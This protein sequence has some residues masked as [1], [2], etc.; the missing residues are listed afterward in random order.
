ME[1]KSWFLK[2]ISVVKLA[3]ILRGIHKNVSI[4]FHF[5]PANPLVTP[6]HIQPE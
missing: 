5:T 4:G 3:T 1:Q 6:I 2:F